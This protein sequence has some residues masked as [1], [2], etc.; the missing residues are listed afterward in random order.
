MLSTCLREISVVERAMRSAK[1]KEERLRA[2]I[3]LPP[4][5]NP[6]LYENVLEL[7]ELLDALVRALETL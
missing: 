5:H 2:A 3:D 7:A 4:E 6:K 1:N